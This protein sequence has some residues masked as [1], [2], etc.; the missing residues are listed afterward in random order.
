MMALGDRLFGGVNGDV[1]GATHEIARA[2]VVA[3]LALIP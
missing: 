3:S 1:A 2:L